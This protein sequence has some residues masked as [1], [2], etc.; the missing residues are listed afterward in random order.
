M[1]PIAKRKA[2][3]RTW[4]IAAA[5]GCLVLSCLILAA[6]PRARAEPGQRVALVIGN[7]AYQSVAK[8]PNAANDARLVAQTLVKLGFKLVGDGAQIDVD[9]P[10]FD[11]LIQTFGTQIA[12]ADVALF[13]YAGHGMQIRGTNF[14]VPVSANP[15]R[16]TDVDFQMVDTELVLRQMEAGN[17]KLNMLILDACRNNPFSGRGLRG[18]GGGLAQMVAPL[19]TLISYA[20][21]PGNVAADGADG[22]SPYTKALVAAMQAPGRGLFDVFNQV[23]LAVKAST[24]GEQQPWVSSSPIEGQFFFVPPGSTVTIQTPPSGAPAP[25]PSPGPAPGPDAELLF[26]QTIATSHDP[27]DFKAYLD[28]YPNGR[29]VALARPRS[30]VPP[31]QT[32]APAAPAAPTGDD[33]G[34]QCDTLAGSTFDDSLPSGVHGLPPERVDAAAAIPVCERAVASHPTP[35][36]QFELA[37]AY[38]VARRDT[39]AVRLYTL[40]AAQGYALAQV[41]LGNMYFNGLG[42]LPKDPVEAVRLY[43]L[44]A[45]QGISVAQ[46]SLGLLYENGQGGV[47]KNVAEAVRFYRLAAAQGYAPAQTNLGW[48]YETGAG[49]LPK[50]EVEATRLYRLAAAQEFARAQTALGLMYASGRGGVTRDDAEAVRL[51][52]LAAAQ[53]YAPALTNLGW[54]YQTGTGGVQ[55]DDAEAV[56]LFKLA[57]EKHY[58]RAEANLAIMY[59]NGRGGLPRD[60]KQAVRL[61]KLAASQGFAPAQNYVGWLYESGT[62]GTPKDERE[63]ARLY[64]LAA[65]QGDARAQIHLG[66]MYATGRGGLSRNRV[67]AS[68]LYHLAE[69]Q[70]PQLAKEALRQL[71]Q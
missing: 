39:D 51:F 35:R 25:P 46:T 52:R 23:G 3:E 33:A 22:D 27:A 10:H 67:E 36:W 17:T 11:T 44:G 61:A 63:A 12:G 55:R 40:A 42:G 1:L 18:V 13:Y 54:L 24:G 41:N 31:S 59:E 37:R 69:A 38:G 56:R 62:E 6:V 5:A 30:I 16:E 71:G 29:F 48:L 21:Q 2:T 64:Q 45:A 20:T 57:A 65:A 68:R 70:E 49:G 66:L 50:D 60:I 58:A 43:K 4:S 32:P 34:R 53:G 47:E 7:S 8:I 28:Q 15:V 9:K 14:L 26:W 19:G